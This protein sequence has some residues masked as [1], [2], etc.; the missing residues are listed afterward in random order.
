[1]SGRRSQSNRGTTRQASPQPSADPS[2]PSV[3]AH[4]RLVALG[5][6]CRVQIG[7]AFKSSAYRDTGIRLL[8]GINIIPGGIR[9]RDVVHFPRSQLSAVED[10]LLRAGD[11]VI[12]MDRPI[13]STGLK[14]ARLT[15]SDLPALLLQRVARLQLEPELDPEYVYR[16]L[17]SDWFRGHCARRASGTQVP[18]LR[19][20]DLKTAPLPLPPTAEQRRIV[21]RLDQLNARSRRIGD[22]LA[23]ATPR[24]EALQ[25]ATV[26]SALRGALTA[27]WRITNPRAEPAHAWLQRVHTERTRLRAN[28]P[29]PMRRVRKDPATA[30]RL[31]QAPP[32]DIAVA[33]PPTWTWA[34]IGQL[35]WHAGYGAPS[36]CAIDGAGP[37]V[38]RIPNIID[39][40]IALTDLKRARAAL[41]LDADDYLQPGDFLAIRTNGSLDQLG[42]AALIRPGDCDR[43]DGSYRP[44]YFA[45][46]LIRFRLAG[47]PELHRW[48]NYIWQAPFVR[49]WIADSAAT[50]SGQ[51][52]IGMPALA[53]CPVPI[54][55]EP[56]ARAAVARIDAL[57]A[58]RDRLADRTRDAAEVHAQLEAT[59]VARALSGKL[60][61]RHPDEQPVETLLAGI[62]ERRATASAT[63]AA[64]RRRHRSQTSADDQAAQPSLPFAAHDSLPFE[65]IITRAH[66]LLWGQGPVLDDDAIRAV[67]RSLRTAG[68]CRFKLLRRDGRLYRH[69]CAA[70]EEATHTERATH[71]FDRPTPGHFR[72]IQ[73]DPRDY[74]LAEWRS[75]LLASLTESTR[76]SVSG[77]VPR[78]RALS[79][80][81]DWARI[82]LGLLDPRPEADDE[83]S[84]AMAGLRS[85]LNSA[86]RRK[87]VTRRGH[88]FVALA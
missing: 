68:L 42:R 18:H 45:S 9:W 12:A 76:T 74:S 52:N 23:A 69:I 17:H 85:A 13:I 25:R 70:L 57:M 36:K 88:R 51:Y 77:V 11:I 15:E 31:E 62:A 8:R 82:N 7:Y 67:A 87:L 19:A 61:A 3:P 14:A 21:A 72:T 26:S 49:T 80:A 44:T 83:R 79:A 47:P 27:D 4:W 29:A 64:A 34:T 78:T 63:R 86:I 5:E 56:E 30:A 37:P 33:L 10:Y 38:L 65:A 40:R 16:Y 1:M 32:T 73:P 53:A 39:G 24:M 43:D 75:V 60:V 55:P 28:A 20:S 54:P 35:A 50:S 22:A 81:R 48:L 84:L 58:R 46:Y 59:L 66:P 71:R 6:V 41:K 2:P